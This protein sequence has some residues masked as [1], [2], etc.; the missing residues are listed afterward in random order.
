MG[1]RKEVNF[2][3]V[4]KGGRRKNDRLTETMK[5]FKEGEEGEG[6][7]NSKQRKERQKGWK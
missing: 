4:V 1:E 6:N 7:G 2:M 3:E 5:V